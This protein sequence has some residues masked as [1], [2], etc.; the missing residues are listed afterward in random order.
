M[1]LARRED[2]DQVIVITREPAYASW[3]SSSL[4]STSIS[5][6]LL[7]FRLNER[8]VA[9]GVLIANLRHRVLQ[10][11]ISSPSPNNKLDEDDRSTMSAPR[12]PHEMKVEYERGKVRLVPNEDSDDYRIYRG[13]DV[14]SYCVLDDVVHLHENMDKG[15]VPIYSEEDLNRYQGTKTTYICASSNVKGRVPKPPMGF[16]IVMALADGRYGIND[17]GRH[18]QFVSK[19]YEWAPCIPRK[20]KELEFLWWTPKP[21]DS[22]PIKSTAIV[23]SLR[24]LKKEH[25]KKL[26]EHLHS[27]S[28]LAFS[29]LE[30]NPKA[31]LLSSLITSAKHCFERLDCYGLVITDILVTVADFQRSCLDIRG[32]V[33]F[34]TVFYPRSLPLT[35]EESEKIWPVDMTIMG[36]FTHSLKEAQALHGMGI[37]SWCVRPQFM[38]NPR[39]T[40]VYAGAERRTVT[41]DDDVETRPYLHPGGKHS[42]FQVIY[43]GP[44]SSTLQIALSRRSP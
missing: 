4:S 17:R 31:T 29:T 32:I 43:E 9:R 13:H 6:A 12:V 35:R 28:E 10:V 40:I 20:C 38:F 3:Y 16:Q 14:L 7:S 36:G 26:E 25:L 22:V 44:P 2:G 11:R 24:V 23:V 19:G 15:G 5:S 8:R 27:A 39:D 1:G 41:V 42:V 37:P 30:K 34:I 21:E 33:L 18:P